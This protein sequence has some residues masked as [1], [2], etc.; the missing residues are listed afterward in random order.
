MQRIAIT[1]SSGYYGR[2]MIRELRERHP[3]V[4]ILGTDL[5]DPSA[6]APDVFHRLDIR[7]EQLHGTLAEFAP[8]TILHLA[9]IVNP[10]RDNGLMREVNIGGTRNMLECVRAIRPQRFLLASSATAYGAWPDNPLPI[11]ESWHIRGRPEYAYSRDKAQIEG[12]LSE[13]ALELPDVA[14]SW[15]RPGIIYGAGA[16]NY[17]SEFFL[18]GPVIIL[19]GGSD[20]PVQFVH[21]HDVAS[22]T[23]TI[24]EN[25]GRGPFNIGPPDWIT[26][27]EVAELSGRRALKAPFWSCL[28]FTNLWWALRIPLFRFPS[29]LWYFMRHPWVIGPE[30]LTNE[31]G[32]RFQYNTRQTVL[33]LLE[34]HR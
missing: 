22:A 20:T 13:F 32:F 28:A 30:R 24:L 16:S 3:D 34:V 14:V 15:T 8:D 33:A 21:E 10:I 1:G 29:G 11:N 9:F 12:L 25:D 5:A 19:P 23:C 27:R 17:L 7:S 18:K 4:R 31:L 6:D 26:L 2:I